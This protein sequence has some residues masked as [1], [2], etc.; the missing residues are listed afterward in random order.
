VMDWVPEKSFELRLDPPT[1]ENSVPGEEHELTLDEVAGRFSK[2]TGLAGAGGLPA[3]YQ[4][5]LPLISRPR[6]LE[7]LHGLAVV[8]ALVEAKA[9]VGLAAAIRAA[10]ASAL[11]GEVG[12]VVV[13]P[14]VPR[15]IL[16]QV[17]GQV[18]FVAPGSRVGLCLLPGWETFSSSRRGLVL[19]SLL[20]GYE[21]PVVFA[22]SLRSAGLLAGEGRSLDLARPAPLLDGV[23]RIRC[24]DGRLLCSEPRS[25]GR[26]RLSLICE[27]GQPPAH[28]ITASEV[29]VESPE[30]SGASLVELAVMLLD[31]VHLPGRQDPLSLALQR[32]RKVLKLA[33][34][35]EAEFIIDV[36]YGVGSRD[37]IEEV[38]EPLRERLLELGVLN[39][40][41]GATRKVTQDLG[42]FPVEQQI[43]Q[44]GVSVAPKVLLAL[45]V[46]GAPQ[47]MDYIGERAVVF[48]FNKDPLAPIMLWN[49]SRPRPVVLPVVGDL[50]VEVPRFLDAL[51]RF[52]DAR[53][54]GASTPAE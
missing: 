13:A 30:E 50:F 14:K 24:M 27:K 23:D 49:K 35:T 52:L 31:D 18:L 3:A 5:D 28:L 46:S 47:H 39:I 1:E 54:E 45:G 19:E 34:L 6:F 4:G 29:R 25:G 48:A 12:V 41:V 15:E 36:G 8:E 9:G 44:T 10:Q 37:G 11:P 51:A 7:G 22:W 38:V 21:G 32:A 53:E 17:A 42:L 2:E 33:S 26:L 20:D 43:G 40:Q 16:R